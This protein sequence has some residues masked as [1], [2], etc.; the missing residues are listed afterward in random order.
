[1]LRSGHSLTGFI[2]H[3]DSYIFYN[4]NFDIKDTIVLTGSP[5]SGTTWLMEILRVIPGYTDLFEPLNPIYFPEAFEVGFQSRTYL[6][7]KKNWQ[8]GEKYLREVLTSRLLHDA[9]SFEK[10]NYK[11]RKIAFHL[12]SFLHQLKPEILMHQLVGNKLVVKFIRLNRL[13]P[14][15][16]ERFQLRKMILIIRHPCSVVASQL[17]IGFC[18]YHPTFPPYGD[19]YP[20]RETILNEAS[21]IDGL[22][23]G[24]LDRL[25]KIKSLEEILAVSWCLDNYVPLSCPK[26]YPWIVIAYETLIKDGEQEIKR[27]FNEI[28]EQNVRR[29]AFRHLKIPSMQIQKGEYDIVTKAD[30]QLSKWKK[31]LSDKQIERILSIVSAFGLDFYTED[32]EPDYECIDI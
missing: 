29:S 30:E 18:G 11:K 28:G 32:L 3:L 14:W 13:L 17:R 26:P 10:G 6:P 24:L 23:R 2:R 15:V 5:R 12:F 27:I 7:P 25:K 22:S 1:M 20:N 4:K 9:S 19:I 8:E 31:S 16:A 21:K